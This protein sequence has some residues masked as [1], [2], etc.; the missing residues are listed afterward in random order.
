MYNFNAFLA[1]KVIK[2]EIQ[3][4]PNPAVVD[5]KRLCTIFKG[6]MSQLTALGNFEKKCLAKRESNF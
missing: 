6:V 3:G 4:H 1:Y 5:G 2:I